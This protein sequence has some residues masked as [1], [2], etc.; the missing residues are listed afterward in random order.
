MARPP[1]HPLGAFVLLCILAATFLSSFA[2]T[3]ALASSPAQQTETPTPAPTP[4]AAE[5]LSNSPGESDYP[6]LVIDGQGAL[7]LFW[8]DSSERATG[9]DILY[10]RRQPNGAWSAPENLTRDFEINYDD[11]NRALLNSAGEVCLAWQALKDEPSTLGVYVRCHV[12]GAWDV[13]QLIEGTGVSHREDMPVFGADGTL[14][15]S[16]IV[17]A[18]DLY[19]QDIKLSDDQ[20]AYRPSFIRD[21][22]GEYHAVWTRQGD[23]FTLVHRYSTDGGQTWRAAETI[24]SPESPPG[25]TQALAPDTQGRV[26]L[27]WVSLDGD[28]FY[29]RWAPDGSWSPPVQLNPDAPKNS[30]TSLGIAAN[31]QGLASVVWQASGSL[32]Y[33]EQRADNAWSSPRVIA[34]SAGGGTGPR[35]TI[36]ASGAR[37]LAW[38]SA[39]NRA[40]ILYASFSPNGVISANVPGPLEYTSPFFRD[41]IHDPSLLVSLSPAVIATNL[42]LALLL[43]LAMGFFGNL[44][45]DTLEAHEERVR[46]LLGPLNNLVARYRAFSRQLDQRLGARRILWLGRLVQVAALVLLIG[47][48]LAFIDPGFEPTRSD[49]LLAVIALALS[50]GIV[51]IVDDLA[52]Y[53]YLRRHGATPVLR[54][55]AGNMV[56]S[57]LS[58]IFTRAFQVTPGLLIGSPAGIEEVEEQGRGAYLGLLAFGAIGLVSLAAWL[59]APLVAGNLLLVTI[60]LLIFGVGVQSL[61]FEMLPLRNLYG[62]TIFEYNRV[63][64]VVLLAVV[65]WFFL[66]TM[67]NPAGEFLGA[68]I[69]PDMIALVVAVAVFCIVSAGVWLYFERTP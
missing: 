2:L 31:S 32:L 48:I 66:T 69:Q 57:I 36:D 10:R 22:A 18:G 62:K 53:W 45:N 38:R 24:N 44:L 40:D 46:Q 65:A 23:P 19:F 33:V 50:V 8:M 26:H 35:L 4:V 14:K 58:V 49:A 55:H 27:T 15:T 54:V 67:L 7:H 47:L 59:I 42:L 20:A 28:L 64:W 60:L 21:Q 17:G 56:L 52:Q 68:F 43:A 29:R 51:N 41:H 1:A 12:G 63:L 39:D 3:P 61:F 11:S 9:S 37:H 5:N 30:S 25:G 16:Y 6:D 34:P 13:A